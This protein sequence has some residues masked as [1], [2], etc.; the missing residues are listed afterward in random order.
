MAIFSFRPELQLNYRQINFF[1]LQLL[2]FGNAND[3]SHAASFPRPRLNAIY[4]SA[5]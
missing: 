3:I 1:I 4:F 2:Q 5:L